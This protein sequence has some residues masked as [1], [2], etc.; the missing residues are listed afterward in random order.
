MT[1]VTSCRLHA[2]T[3]CMTCTQL[4]LAPNVERMHPQN[5]VSLT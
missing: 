4:L 3:A 5:L 2:Y 1:C